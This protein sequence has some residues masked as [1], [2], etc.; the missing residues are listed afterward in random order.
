MMIVIKTSGGFAGLG[1]PEKSL[2]TDSLAA[3]QRQAVCDAFAPEV[4]E[5]LQA[6]PGTRN[7]GADRYSYEITIVGDGDERRTFTLPEAVLPPQMLDMI[8]DM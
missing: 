5:K 7:I 1:G 8:D 6:M 4:L 3:G 2:A